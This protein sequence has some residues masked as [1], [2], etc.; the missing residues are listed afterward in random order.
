MN[1]D[2]E[3]DSGEWLLETRALALGRA[4]RKMPRGQVSWEG[5]AGSSDAG[6]QCSTWWWWGYQRVLLCLL[7][8]SPSASVICLLPR[9]RFFILLS[10]QKILA[11]VRHRGERLSQSKEFIVREMK[12]A[13]TVTQS[14]KWESRHLHGSHGQRSSGDTKKHWEG[15]A[16]GSSVGPCNVPF[17]YK[18]HSGA[19]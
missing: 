12:C 13:N 10:I 3:V 11:C 1:Q 17:S 9:G 16:R 15:G 18:A 2:G 5:R 7:S 19:V 14:R 4:T 6:Q 8:R